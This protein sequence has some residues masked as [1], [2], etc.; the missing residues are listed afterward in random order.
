LKDKIRDQKKKTTKKKTDLNIANNAGVPSADDLS[1]SPSSPT[2]PTR[3]RQKQEREKKKRRK[4]MRMLGVSFQC[5]Y[6][7]SFDGSTDLAHVPITVAHKA[8]S[9]QHA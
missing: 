4:M 5:T 8:K 6:F 7:E 3:A 2:V 9:D 1:S